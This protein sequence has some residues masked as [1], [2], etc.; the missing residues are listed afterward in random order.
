M[1]VFIQV[2]DSKTG[3]FQHGVIDEP[4]SAGL[5]ITNAL[6]HFGIDRVTWIQQVPNEMKYGKV[7][8]TSKIVNVIT[9]QVVSDQPSDRCRF[10]SYP[11][12]LRTEVTQMATYRKTIGD[13]Q[14]LV[15]KISSAQKGICGK[16]YKNQ[17]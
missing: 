2:I 13:S 4:V 15:N 12:S 1:K 9:I 10:E 7:D 8:D 14:L 3:I 16:M 17:S 6:K 5:E 11:W